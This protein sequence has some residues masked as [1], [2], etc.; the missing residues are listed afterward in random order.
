MADEDKVA[1]TT[2]GECMGCGTTEVPVVDG[3]CSDVCETAHKEKLAE[4]S[5][6][7]AP[8]RETA[9]APLHVTPTQCEGCEEDAVTEDREGVPLCQGCADVCEED[10]TESPFPAVVEFNVSGSG[11]EPLWLK[12]E[13]HKEGGGK[14]SGCVLDTVPKGFPFT[15]VGVAELASDGTWVVTDAC[16][17]GLSGN[18]RLIEE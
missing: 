2:G 4:V 14:V 13:V 10:A 9:S 5:D 1:G 16:E 15:A 8:E 6:A 11:R 7:P 3:Y 12:L 17:G 18:W